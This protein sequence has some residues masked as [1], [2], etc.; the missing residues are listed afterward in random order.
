MTEPVLFCTISTIQASDISYSYISLLAS[1]THPPAIVKMIQLL[2]TFKTDPADQT[3]VKMVYRCL[4]CDDL[5]GK[6][7]V[8]LGAVCKVS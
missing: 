8:F 2:Y 4:F 6:K 1:H 5:V 7:G 3:P